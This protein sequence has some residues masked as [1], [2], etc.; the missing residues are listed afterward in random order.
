MAIDAAEVERLVR[1]ELAR[2]TEE[3]LR[4]AIEQFR[5]AP[6]VEERE[7]DYGEPGQ[8]HPCWMVVEHPPSNFGIAYCEQGFGPSFP[9]GVIFLVG[10]QLNIGMD[11]CWHETLE[12]ALRDLMSFAPASE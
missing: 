12:E 4:R 1:A 10:E 7:W 6:R 8:T 5:I 3:K 11:C 2:I 9:W